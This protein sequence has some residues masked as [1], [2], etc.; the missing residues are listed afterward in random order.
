MH[1]PGTSNLKISPYSLW[2]SSRKS[3]SRLMFL[4][5]SSKL[6]MIGNCFGPGISLNG[7]ISSDAYK[8]CGGAAAVRASE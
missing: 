4:L 3:I 5:K 8:I 1:L 2:H 7:F 6:R